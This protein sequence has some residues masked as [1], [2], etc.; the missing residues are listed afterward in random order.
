[1][2]VFLKL[3]SAVLALVLF[4]QCSSPKPASESSAT[5]SAA[6]PERKYADS[7]A[8]LTQI[9]IT[10][11][12][13]KDANTYE[14]Y[15]FTLEQEEAIADMLTDEKK[16]KY[17]KREFG[18]SLHEELAYFENITKYIEK[19]G[20]DLDKI[21]Y[22]LVEAVD[23]NRANYAPI[24]LKEVIIPIIQEGVERDIVFVAIENDGKWYFTSELSL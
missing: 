20:I 21:D 23:Y 18:F 13:N 24:N 19:V 5:A 11:L 22:T 15:C 6:E 8:Q 14:S 12:K 3:L 9:L 2:N 17:F 1:M 7:L 16:Q 10:S 4:F